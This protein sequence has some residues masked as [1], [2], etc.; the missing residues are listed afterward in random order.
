MFY[1]LLLKACVE[2]PGDT[3]SQ[4]WFLFPQ[5]LPIFYTATRVNLEVMSDHISTLF[6]IL[7]WPP[8]HSES[9]SNP[10]SS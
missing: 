3:I 5:F 4:L 10:Y 2:F 8:P 9:R 6:K 1:Y 7:Q